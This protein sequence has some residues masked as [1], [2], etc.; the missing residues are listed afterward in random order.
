M[1]KN[2]FRLK[3][4]VGIRLDLQTSETIPLWMLNAPLQLLLKVNGPPFLFTHP[5][6]VP[7]AHPG[8]LA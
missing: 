1:R 3:I 2:T 6:P 5:L 4:F 7:N 8:V